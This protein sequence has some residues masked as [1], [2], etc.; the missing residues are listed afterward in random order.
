MFY[1]LH[2]TVFL[3]LSSRL[4]STRCAAQVGVE[5]AGLQAIVHKLAGPYGLLPSILNGKKSI[6]DVFGPIIKPAM[7][8]VA[9]GVIAA[10]KE[11][12]FQQSEGTSK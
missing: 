1:F 10:M 7:G 11:V 9:D 2:S 5:A 4:P 12:G 6:M 8:S 3:L